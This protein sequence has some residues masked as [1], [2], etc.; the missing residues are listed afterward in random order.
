MLADFAV[1]RARYG[2]VEEATF[3]RYLFWWSLRSRRRRAAFSHWVRALRARD[4]SFSRRLLVEDFGY[5]VR[6]SA[7]ELLSRGSRGRWK[8]RRAAAGAGHPSSSAD[9]YLDAARRWV[10]QCN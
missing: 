2:T 10:A 6:D 8:T 7:D 3:R 9:P 4:R 1:L 5:L